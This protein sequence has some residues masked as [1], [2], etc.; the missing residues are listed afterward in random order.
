MHHFI[1][2][3]W[4]YN[5]L[6]T[7]R[8]SLVP[9]VL[10]G[11]QNGPSLD[12]PAVGAGLVR[13]WRTPP[14]KTQMLSEEVSAACYLLCGVQLQLP[15]IRSSPMTSLLRPWTLSCSELVEQLR[16]GG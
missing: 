3:Y 15:V 12:G 11:R 1:I 7:V 14:L 13:D 9:H 16:Y 6:G 4:I 8:V 10:L 2:L 5:N